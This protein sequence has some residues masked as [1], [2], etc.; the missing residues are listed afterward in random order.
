ADAYVAGRYGSWTAAK[1]FW[2]ANG[3]Y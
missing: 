1:A 3:W 2:Q